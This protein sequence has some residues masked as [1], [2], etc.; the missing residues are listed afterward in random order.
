MKK[1]SL[2]TFKFS[3]LEQKVKAAAFKQKGILYNVDLLKNEQNLEEGIRIDFSGEYAK[4][5]MVGLFN[6]KGTKKMSELIIKADIK[7]PEVKKYI[8]KIFKPI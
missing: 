2:S 1:I 5:G 4:N 7:Y 8:E 3:K 6:I